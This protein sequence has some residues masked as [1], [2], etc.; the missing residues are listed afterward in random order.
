MEVADNSGKVNADVQFMA[1]RQAIVN[2]I[3]AYSYL[4]DEGRWEEWF[5][6]FSDDILF[7][8][9]TPEL[10]TVIARGKKVFRQI[11][12]DRYIT[13]GKTSASVRR[14]TAGNVHVAEQTAT[15]AKVR[16]YMLISNVPNADK[17]H[18]LTTGT[19]NA[20]LEKRDGKWIIT[21]WYIEADAPLAPSGL[22]E[23]FT[24]DEFKWIPDPSTAMPGAVPGPMKGLLSVKNMPYAIPAGGPLYNLAPKWFWKNVDLVLVDYLTDAKSA[25]ALL[26]DSLTTFPIVE[27]PGYSAV[28]LLW[29]RYEDSSFGPYDEFFVTIPCLYKGAIYLYVPFIYVDNDSA[30]ASGREIGGFP[31]KIADI[32]MERFGGTYNVSLT[33]RGKT[34]VSASMQIGRKLVSTPLPADKPVVL[35][36]PYNMTFP[37]PAPTGK[38]Q[39]NI[40]LATMSC[41]LVPGVGSD[42]PPPELAQLISSPWQVNGDIY[43]GSGTSLAFGKSEED[44]LDCLPNLQLLGAMYFQGQM[45]LAIGAIK[46]EEDLLKK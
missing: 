36:Y 32:K 41:K 31:K 17:L 8:N 22:P 23:G 26:P 42:T 27:L 9:T 16:T 25:A 2:T 6:L 34:V 38:P 37:L 15:T 35:P 21:R 44:P 19:Y 14:H 4:I 39:E 29:A 30:M 18:V 33:R 45:T 43:G 11:A 3:T 24:E 46:V 12:T 7:E 10:G 5:A 1:D 20:E 40:P 28:K 13:P